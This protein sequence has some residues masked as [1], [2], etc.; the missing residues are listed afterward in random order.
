LGVVFVG[1]SGV[2]E[3]AKNGFDIGL[4]GTGKLNNLT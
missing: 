4:L 3:D 2:V 1:K